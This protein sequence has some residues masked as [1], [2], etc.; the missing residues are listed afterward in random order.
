VRRIL[1]RIYSLRM[2][3]ASQDYYMLARQRDGIALTPVLG[4]L[5]GGEVA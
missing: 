3:S 1:S 2:R 5:E 4:R